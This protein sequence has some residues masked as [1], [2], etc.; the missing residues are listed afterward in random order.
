MP[1]QRIPILASSDHEN[2]DETFVEGAQY[3]RN[4]MYDKYPDGRPYATQRPGITITDTPEFTD[5]QKRG[6]G[7]YNWQKKDSSYQVINDTVYSNYTEVVGTITAGL[8]LVFF[9]ETDNELAIIDPENNEGWVIDEFNV[10]TKIT[11]SNFPPNQSTAKTLAGGVAWVDGNLYV[12]DTDG[13]IWNSNDDDPYT[14]DALGFINAGRSE[15]GGIFIAQHATGIAVFGTRSIEFFYNAG[16]PVGSPL[17]RRNDLFFLVGA[18]NTNSVSVQ[19]NRVYF[20][21]SEETGTLGLYRLEDFQVQKISTKSDDDLL[22][23]AR[24]VKKLEFFLSGILL[25]SHQLCFVSGVQSIGDGLYFA[26]A[27]YIESQGTYVLVDGTDLYATQFTLVWDETIGQWSN[28]DSPALEFGGFPVIN[29]T[30]RLRSKN[31]VASLLMLNGEIVEFSPSFEPVDKTSVKAYFE[32]DDYI[33]NQDDYVLV[34]GEDASFGIP[35]S[36][37]LPEYDGGT[38]TLKFCHRLELVGTTLA[39]G[40]GNSD[41]F[42]SWSD[43][44]YRTVSPKRRLSTSF[45]QKLSRLGKFKRRSYQIDYDGLEPLRIEGVEMYLRA[46]QYA[47]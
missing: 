29:G 37:R 43:D 24:H 20:L 38:M 28:Y 1:I 9:A 16:N 23:E 35:M 17:Q 47:R 5:R 33:V 41:I 46:S 12:L 4:V 26:D 22:A 39:D 8:N 19:G 30:S 45:R 40:V 18:I 2:N 11:D 21:G 27:D 32:P 6:R 14:W 42:V 31:T 15:D 13:F 10:L 3:A 44:H 7:A 34:N 36:V 25:R